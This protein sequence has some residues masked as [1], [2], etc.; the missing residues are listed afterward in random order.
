MAIP[1][2]KGNLVGT[3][4]AAASDL[5]IAVD[6]SILNGA[7]AT[8]TTIHVPVKCSALICVQLS[9]GTATIAAEAAASAPTFASPTASYQVTR[10]EPVF[11]EVPVT[12]AVPYVGIKI[13]NQ[14]GATLTVTKIGMLVLGK[15]KLDQD[16]YTIANGLSM[17]G[18]AYNNSTATANAQWSLAD[19]S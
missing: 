9:S 11:L 1:S 7:S 16:V 14:S 10:G 17:L 13:T 4:C 19:Q 15:C 5:N 2:G 8:S 6:T 18:G 12:T 3:L